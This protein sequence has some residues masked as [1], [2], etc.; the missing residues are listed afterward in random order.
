[1]LNTAHVVWDDGFVWV[2]R[3]WGINGEAL[4][5][6]TA[7]EQTTGHILHFSSGHCPGSITWT[8]DTQRY[9]FLT[10]PMFLGSC[11]LLHDFLSFK[12]QIL[13]T[14]SLLTASLMPTVLLLSGLARISMGLRKN[15]KAQTR[16]ALLCL[17]CSFSLGISRAVFIINS[18]RRFLGLGKSET[19]Q[20]LRLKICRT[21]AGS[22]IIPDPKC[23]LYLLTGENQCLC[24][25]SAHF[26]A[27]SR[28]S[29]LKY[30]YCKLPK[31]HS[32]FKL[33]QNGRLAK[34]VCSFKP[35]G[36]R[37]VCQI[38]YISVKCS[39]K[40]TWGA[41]GPFFQAESWHPHWISHFSTVDMCARFCEFSRTALSTE[42]LFQR[43]IVWH[44]SKSVWCKI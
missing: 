8:L 2:K 23:V 21:S 9:P 1:M 20:I 40:A 37:S 31:I 38:L 30:V 4:V 27:L 5:A 39:T 19:A 13:F 16:E 6:D 24:W 26:S 22:E 10:R 36:V 25:M 35:E 15:R 3:H 17:S 18:V 32:I 33:V 14:S 12:I 34:T 7:N 43:W 28:K 41:I 42:I 29:S 11:T 44:H